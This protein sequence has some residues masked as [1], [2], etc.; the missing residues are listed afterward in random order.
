MRMLAHTT[1]TTP[2]T[3]DGVEI[4]ASLPTEIVARTLPGG[5]TDPKLFTR[6]PFVRAELM[7]QTIEEMERD[8]VKRSDVV[9]ALESYAHYD[10]AVWT[11][12]KAVPA[13]CVCIVGAQRW[14]WMRSDLSKELFTELV[15]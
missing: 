9:R 5:E 10:V 8:G 7:L 2:H 14:V 6:A 11:D 3:E 1:K 4:S 13:V 15:L 12:N